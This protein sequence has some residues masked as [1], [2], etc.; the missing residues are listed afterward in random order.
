[1]K[2]RHEVLFN[3]LKSYRSEV[4]GVV[5]NVSEKEAEIVPKGFKNNIRWNLGHIYL[6]QYL[7]LQAMTK[8]KADV[9]EQFNSWFGFGTSPSDFDTETPSLEELKLLLKKQPAQIKEVYGDRIEEEFPA[10]DMGME[11]IEQVLVR[12]VFHEGMHLQ[13]I[14]DLKKCIENR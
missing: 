12:T 6:D 2:K 1:M 13:A 5:D 9:P 10:I 14:L 3:Q 7:W 4:L 11:T 8:E